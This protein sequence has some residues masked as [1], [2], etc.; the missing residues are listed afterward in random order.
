MADVR[1]GTCHGKAL[2]DLPERCFAQ[3][4]GDGIF[5]PFFAPAVKTLRCFFILIILRNLI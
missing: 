2:K 1:A 4:R 5:V 3:V